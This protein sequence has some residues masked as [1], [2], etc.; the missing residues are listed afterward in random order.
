MD[1]SV[2]GIKTS[3]FKLVNYIRAF[4]NGWLAEWGVKDFALS[5]KVTLIIMCSIAAL[6]YIMFA[7]SASYKARRVGFVLWT[8]ILVGSIG[9]GMYKVNVMF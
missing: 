6:G 9:S 3:F 7:K 5:T 4:L 2:V 1:I 8:L